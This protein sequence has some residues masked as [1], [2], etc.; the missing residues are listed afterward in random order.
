[1]AMHNSKISTVNCDW[2]VKYH[3]ALD[4]EGNVICIDDITEVDRKKEFRCLGCGELMVP[5]LGKKNA[6][7]FAHKNNVFHCNPETYL[8]KLAKQKIKDWFDSTKPFNI[9]Y[10]QEVTCADAKTC[11]FYRT[12][13]CRDKK[14]KTYNVKKYYDTCSVEK[15]VDGYIADLLLTSQKNPEFP[16][17]LI[18]IFVTHKCE[19]KK[20]ESNHKIIEIKITSEEDIDNLVESQVFEEVSPYGKNLQERRA[21]F[22][23]GFKTKGRPEHLEMRNIAKF[24]LYRTRKGYVTEFEERPSCR[25]AIKSDNSQAILELAIDSLYSFA[26]D[27]GYAKAKELGFVT[28]ICRRCKY[29]NNPNF[30]RL[31]KKYGT[32]RHPN[33]SDAKSCPYYSQEEIS[34]IVSKTPIVIVKQ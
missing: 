17:I 7:H 28:K 19:V 31:S 12:E 15:S 3:H 21:V 27:I 1:M 4:F 26:Y 8:H 24:Y 18:E 10:Y 20:L 2:Y 29:W 32:P 25:E 22:F 14:Q 34:D 5:R 33:E 9:S 30:C 13:E 6:H 23:Y 11:P 16:P